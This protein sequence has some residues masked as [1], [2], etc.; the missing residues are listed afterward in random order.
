L[1]VFETISKRKSIRS[2]NPT[3][4][5]ISILKNV[6][7]AAR[8]TPS[9]GNAQPWHFIIIK[10]EDKRIRIAKGCRYG[11]FL[12]ESPVIIVACGDKEESS[13]WYAIDTAIAL[14]HLV[15]VA[16]DKGLGTCWIGSFNQEDIR[17][18]LRIPEKFEVIALMALGYPRRKVD[19]LAKLLHLIRPRKKLNDIISLEVY[20]KKPT[21]LFDSDS[22]NI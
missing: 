20:G 19:L 21:A 5:P 12:A 18:I 3:P 11:E 8:L 1:D 17:K 14:E 9:A 15:L 13:R 22:I 4:I 2:Y 16:T 10:D 7:D 6:L